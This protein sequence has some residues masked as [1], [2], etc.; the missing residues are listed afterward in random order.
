[1]VGGNLG[2]PL[3]LLVLLLVLCQKAFMSN[4]VHVK[5]RLWSSTLNL[6]VGGIHAAWLV[7]LFDI[8]PHWQ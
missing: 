2:I 3:K 6:Q 8:K 4:G 5:Q 1:M 7:G